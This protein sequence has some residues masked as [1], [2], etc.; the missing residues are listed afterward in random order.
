M[1]SVV[2]AKSNKPA[3]QKAVQGELTQLLEL[4][5]TVQLL[6]FPVTMTF[7]TL[8]AAHRLCSQSRHVAIHSPA[9]SLHVP[10]PLQGLYELPSAFQGLRRSCDLPPRRAWKL[11]L[12]QAR[13]PLAP[14]LSLW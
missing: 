5:Q 14:V 1:H 2:R 7:Q 9:P 12:P 4:F 8:A 10:E 13:K 11:T 6:S 3:C